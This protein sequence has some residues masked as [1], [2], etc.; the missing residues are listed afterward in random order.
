MDKTPE[1]I[2]DE[3]CKKNNLIRIGLIG[4]GGFGRVFKV[5]SKY[6]TNSVLAIKLYNKGAHKKEKI[7]DFRGPNIIKIF[8][9]GEKDNS[10]FYAMEYSEIGSLSNFQK[11]LDMEANKRVFKNPFLEN[12]GNNLIRYISKQII[13]SLKTLYQLDL[14][15]FDIKPTNILIFGG[16]T[17]KLIDFSLLIKLKG[18]EGEIKGGTKGYLTP[19]YYL[20]NKISNESLRKQDY[21]ALGA[22]IYFLKYGEN[23]LNYEE[24]KNVNERRFFI[25]SYKIINIITKI[26]NKIKSEKYQDVGFTDFLCSLIHFDPE[27]RANFEK[28]YRNKWVNQNSEELKKIYDINFLNEG[29]LLL[30]LQKSDFLINNRKYFKK[31]IDDDFKKNIKDFRIVKKGKYKLYRK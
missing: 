2:V 20:G 8:L 23:M 9:E 16:L 22:V 4:K 12:V 31:K 26:M 29:S 3:I 24:E 1:D 25:N 6:T 28:I 13:I 11:Y 5:K 10:Y 27:S 19:E 17:M 18:K 15:H 14:V 21:F 30:E 7:S